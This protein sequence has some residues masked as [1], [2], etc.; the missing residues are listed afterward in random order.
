MTGPSGLSPDWSHLGVSHT[1][2][3]MAGHDGER[4][5]GQAD[6]DGAEPARRVADS[7]KPH[8]APEP[9]RATEPDT[10]TD[11]GSSPSSPRPAHLLLALTLGCAAVL[12][13]YA[14]F[15]ST[16]ALPDAQADDF[17]TAH[18]FPRLLAAGASA[19]LVLS[20]GRKGGAVA[21]C[22]LA[23][24]AGLLGLVRYA[25][26][27][28]PETAWILPPST[29]LRPVAPL[30]MALM[31]GAVVLLCV[32]LA[33]RRRPWF[34]LGEAAAGRA[35]PVRRRIQHVMVMLIVGSLL[36]GL[37]AGAGTLGA[38][39][40]RGDRETLT[41]PR[42]DVRAVP[43]ERW[44]DDALH[45]DSPTVWPKGVPSKRAWEREFDSPVALS[46]CERKR[47]EGT[48]HGNVYHRGT[49]VGV[50]DD[51]AAEGASVVGVDAR[52]GE[53]RWRY[54][55]PT[56][57]HATINQVGV[58]EGCAVVVLVDNSAT[59]LDAFDGSVRGR[60]LLST[61]HLSEQTNIGGGRAGARW[62]FLTS[63]RYSVDAKGRPPRLVRL[64][65]QEYTFLLTSKLAVLAIRNSDGRLA[66]AG[67]D[68]RACGRLV[69]GELPISGQLMVAE[70]CGAKSRLRAFGVAEH[71]AEDVTTPLL[72]GSAQ[73]SAT[74][75]AEC[76]KGSSTAAV[77]GLGDALV[78]YEGCG[79]DG[80]DAWW[81]LFEPDPDPYQ[82][83]ARWR[84][85]TG[86]P[87][88]VREVGEGTQPLSMKRGYVL[89]HRD[90]LLVVHDFYADAEHDRFVR[91]PGGDPAVALTS[92]MEP[93][94]GPP[95]LGTTGMLVLGASGRVHAV[96]EI[97]VE[98]Y[99]FKVTATRPEP[100]APVA[101]CRD[102]RTGLLVAHTSPTMILT[103]TAE[104]GGATKAVA[105]AGESRPQGS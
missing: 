85:W 93:I 30:A 10:A 62:A 33:R 79:P 57:R 12:A 48:R 56:T 77:T 86:Y 28:R 43:E 88:G 2:G 6:A 64:P 3:V 72:Y 40:I 60:A 59:T 65:L 97:A 66:A 94:T 90:G 46:T 53:Q 50:D 103:C 41:L 39:L 102:G 83:P 51:L 78:L 31:C 99:E 95:H 20:M 105:Y 58:S 75:P 42:Q 54:T 44:Y 91:L 27:S 45:S 25:T 24:T 18:W 22:A 98:D 49:V 67:P 84:R 47:G 63:T 89:P 96:D 73:T 23:A 8:K 14:A 92:S 34:G 81:V 76:E 26:W 16:G 101:D 1:G 7:E 74:I 36:G 38:A 9:D 55:V 32:P 11:A 71:D 35:G 70:D 80:R 61:L 68:D 104:D 13:W 21:A 69:H 29:E 5:T 52:T 4:E 15:P 19:A 82:P 37:L 17:G 100:L 87:S